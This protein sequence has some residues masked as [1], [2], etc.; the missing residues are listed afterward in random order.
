MH[1]TRKTN[2][3]LVVV[4]SLIWLSVLLFCFFAGFAYRTFL[5][6]SRNAVLG[7]GFVLLF[8]IIPL[9]K[10]IVTFD[11]ASQQVRWKRLR[12]FKVAT[13]TVPFSAITGIRIEALASEHGG[14]TYRLAILTADN[15]VP[16]SD[17]YGNGRAHYESLR[18]EILNFLHLDGSKDAST[19][20]VS[21][22][23]SVQSLLME[24]RK[25]EAI[26]LMR[27]SQKIG[28]AEA[29]ERVDAIE[30]KMKAAK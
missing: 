29:V 6:P 26:K 4:D 23:A 15:P 13:G 17:S 7:L 12:M 22:E 19:S 3:E 20:D 18:Q 2:Q 28:L 1:I 14:Q 25:V 9:R 10:E 8:V 5:E 11:A 30:E 24:G 27:S 21:D 16:M